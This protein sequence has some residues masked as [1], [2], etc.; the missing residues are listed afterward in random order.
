MG[1]SQ[2]NILPSVPWQ[3]SAAIIAV[4]LSADVHPT[5]QLI[6]LVLD[7]LVIK[8]TIFYLIIMPGPNPDSF[9]RALDKFKASI[10]PSL[11]KGFSVCSLQDVYSEIKGIQTTQAK[12]DEMPGMQRLQ[13]FVEAMT[14]LG[15]VIEV[16]LNVHEIVCFVW[17]PIKFLLTVANQ[18]FKSLDKLLDAYSR[19][20][21]A[22]PGLLQ[23]KTV[24]EN[25]DSLSTVLEDYYS[26]VL[27]FHLEAL[28]V[29]ARPKWRAL[30]NSAWTTFEAN[31]AP[32]LQSLNRR[33]ELLESLKGTASLYE[34]QRARD[35]IK[36]VHDE[37]IRQARILESQR[38]RLIMGEIKIKLQSP[39]YQLDQEQ[40][41]ESNDANESGEWMFTCPEFQCWYDS[42]LSVRMRHY[43][44]NFSMSFQPSREKF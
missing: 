32:I 44:V 40:L 35:D 18:H 8:A 39:E 22:I 19:I 33:R 23:Y 10:D 7:F 4:K 37:Q 29:F 3:V 26:D 14:Q 42:S 20:G 1:F 27:N 38:N 2:G 41:S 21:D 16:F 5:F 6:P 17:G 36:T 13:A 43:R 11:H 31:F 24:F 15:S 28:R 12:K 9:K 34:I 30:F 25:N